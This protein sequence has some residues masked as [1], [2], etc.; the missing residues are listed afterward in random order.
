[1]PATWRVATVTRAPPGLRAAAA[2][3]ARTPGSSQCQ[4][5]NDATTE[6]AG[7]NRQLLERGV[8]VLHVGQLRQA[9]PSHVEQGSARL[10][11]RDPC[12]AAREIPRRLPG[13]AA[14]LEHPAQL[15]VTG[16]VGEEPLRE[17][18]RTRS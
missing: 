5:V 10:D 7:L 9:P 17:P 16:Q 18:G 11:G 2:L 8:H 3:G 13:A 1:P 6:G 4:A 14:D 15:H 12:A